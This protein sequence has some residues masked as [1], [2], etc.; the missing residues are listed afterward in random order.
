[1]MSKLAAVI[2]AASLLPTLAEAQNRNC[3]PRTKVLETLAGKYK[4]SRR[5]IGLATQGRVMEI[6]ASEET[7]SWTITV[8]MPNGMTCLVASGQA[9]EDIDEELQPAGIRS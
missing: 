2:L 9:F 6:F 4:E 1:M 8:T 7:G 3:G 5:S